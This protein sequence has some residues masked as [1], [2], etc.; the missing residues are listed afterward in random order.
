MESGQERT[1]FYV[2]TPKEDYILTANKHWYI[3]E[4]GEKIDPK[5][6][7]SFVPI[8]EKDLRTG[9]DIETIGKRMH[10]WGK[11]R[12]TK[13]KWQMYL[14]DNVPSDNSGDYLRV[15]DPCN[16]FKDNAI[17]HT[18]AAWGVDNYIDNFQLRSCVSSAFYE[19]GINLDDSSNCGECL[20]SEDIVE[21][22]DDFLLCISA[23]DALSE[24]EDIVIG[25]TIASMLKLNESQ[26][27]SLSN[28]PNL[29]NIIWNS[30]GNDG[31]CDAGSAA[32]DLTDAVLN[33]GFV[34][35]CG[36]DTTSDEMVDN[37]LA[38]LDANSDIDDFYEELEEDY[39]VIFINSSI[40]ACPQY[41]C[42]IREMT[43]GSLASSYMC[44]LL[45][46]FTSGSSNDVGFPL[47][48]YAEDFTANSNLNNVAF[49]GTYVN[50]GFIKDDI[51][52]SINTHNCNSIDTLDMLET[53][54]HELIHAEIKRKLIEIYGWNGDSATYNVAFQ[55]MIQAE[56]GGGIPDE[57]NLM[58]QFFLQEMVNSLKEMNGDIG[59]NDSDYIG[60]I[61]HGLPLSSLNG[62][63]TA[64]Q[65][66]SMYN[67]AIT[68]HKQPG[69]LMT[70]IKTL[71]P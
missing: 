52:I 18:V 6:L 48:F 58:F 31:A 61:L 62:L 40:S 27:N 67:H 33:D 30:I 9:A 12:S 38:N 55:A 42:L 34:A 22:T 26:M 35:I 56:Y 25:N 39:D 1:S 68:F 28:N 64:S 57:H 10:G 44:G 13:T 45:S 23:N 17:D 11:V 29:M 7:L 21:M 5:A 43:S 66:S 51:R 37:T 54:Q 14:S 49:G 15:P 53:I 3:R 8:I 60:L 69:G 71:C 63:Y 47:A 46:N 19:R 4:I 50:N 24:V 36:D 70:T 65:V 16:N 32:D 20:S 2:S 41:A 59:G